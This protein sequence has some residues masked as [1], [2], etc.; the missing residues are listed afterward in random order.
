MKRTLRKSFETKTAVHNAFA[1]NFSVP[2]ALAAIEKLV[3]QT[4]V[5]LG[6]VGQNY[7]AEVLETTAIWITSIFRILG[8]S[9]NPNGLGWTTGDQTSGSEG[10][11]T[12]EVVLPYVRTL[13]TFRDEVRKKLLTKHHILSFYL[14]LIAFVTSI[15]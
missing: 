3:Q 5:Y 15:L 11:S 10:I 2:I 1:D 9:V 6:K 12:E 4:N 13:S 8:F 14:Q 7:R